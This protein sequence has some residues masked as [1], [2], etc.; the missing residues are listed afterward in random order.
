MCLEE[1]TGSVIPCGYLYYGKTRRRAEVIFDDALR[2]RVSSIIS[3]MYFLLENGITPP[4]ELKKSCGSCS[5]VN[6]CVPQ[7][8]LK[9]TVD[10]YLERFV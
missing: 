1:M 5:L 9:K 3:E 2:D 10:S 4:A 7:L 8:S 6:L